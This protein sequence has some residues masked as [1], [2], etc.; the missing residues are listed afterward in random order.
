MTDAGIFHFT[1]RRQ[2]MKKSK[3]LIDK[4]KVVLWPFFLNRNMVK[5]HIDPHNHLT[6]HS[7]GSMVALAIHAEWINPVLSLQVTIASAIYELIKKGIILF[8]DNV[9]TLPFIIC[10]LNWFVVYVQEL[11]I[12]FD[13][14]P[15]NIIVRDESIENGDLV[16]FVDH[17]KHE[18]TNTYYTGDY[19]QG[20]RKSIGI[21]Y[22]KGEKNRHDKKP[23]KDRESIYTTRLEFRLCRNNT[24]Y[25]HIQNLL[26]IPNKVIKNF[27]PLLAVIYNNYFADN[28]NMTVPYSYRHLKKIVEGTG[29]KKQRYRGNLKKAEPFPNR[30]D[31]KEKHQMKTML[32]RAFL[33][34]VED[35]KNG[36]EMTKG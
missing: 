14:K 8:P 33:K 15:A 27:M 28:I 34:E 13:I 3:E 10:N 16:Q 2:D 31:D 6:L 26:D 7:F 32:K 36:K 20:K 24:P 18:K 21:I 23:V 11:E 29:G 5:K 4:V 25:L 35:A 12:A 17:K 22:D 1:I 9:F 19:H 30:L